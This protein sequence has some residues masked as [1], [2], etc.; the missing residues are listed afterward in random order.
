MSTHQR[1]AVGGQLP[2]SD[3]DGD[4]RPGHRPVDP[5]AVE[6][7]NVAAVSTRTTRAG[8]VDSRVGAPAGVGRTYR[9]GGTPSHPT[10]AST[11]SASM[12]PPTAVREMVAGETPTA[13]ARR[14]VLQP[15]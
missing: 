2:Q 14:D 4:V 11:P 8:P 7:T 6:S 9:S 12:T 10:M 15:G 13:A 3:L 1:L 5:P